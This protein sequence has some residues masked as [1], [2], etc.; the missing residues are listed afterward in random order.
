MT[1]W[2]VCGNHSIGINSKTSICQQKTSTHE[3]QKWAMTS[4][5]VLENRS[6]KPG[7]KTP[8]C[9]RKNQHKSHKTG[10][11]PAGV[12]SGIRQSRL[13]AKH[14]L[15]N[16]NIITQGSQKWVVVLT[17]GYQTTSPAGNYNTSRLHVPNVPVHEHSCSLKAPLS[18]TLT[19]HFKS[20]DF[21]SGELMFSSEMVWKWKLV[22][23]HIN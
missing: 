4:W 19:H 13:W 2:W 10:L 9:Q 21:K 3:S 11:G 12:Y 23:F 1:S 14:R 7:S 22:F 17:M 5:W 20:K 15:V 8:V 6:T 16:Q 18:I